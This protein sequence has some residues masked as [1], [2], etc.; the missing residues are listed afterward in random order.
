MIC[1]PCCASIRNASCQGCPYYT[2]AFQHPAA[3]ARPKPIIF[4]I[5]PEVESEVRH[6]VDLLNRGNIP[7]GKSVISRLV[8][9]HPNNYMVAYANGLCYA[10][11]NKLDEAIAAF[12][13]CV[14]INPYC[15][16][17]YFN[18]AVAY[19]QKLNLPKTVAAFRKAIEVGD[20][21][22]EFMKMAS[23]SLK[24]LERIIFDS[25]RL[26]IDVYLK[27]EELFNQGFASML[28]KNF[29]QAIELF[30][31]SLAICDKNPQNHGNI[32]IC[33]ARLG[34]K[35][36]ALQAFDLALEIDPNYE[37]AMV[38]RAIVET[39]A[40]GE[41]LPSDEV[42]VTE[43]YKEYTAQNKSYIQTLLNDPDS[44]TKHTA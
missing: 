42:R 9:S 23:S 19:Q 7:A 15:E 5:N 8:Y 16:E 40:E 28:E 13:A 35:A 21:H 17:A 4:E 14:D 1:P 3:Q 41:S 2:L 27:S 22:D 25:Y 20:P 11:E 39:L 44:I 31:A 43:Y 24:D 38:N 29:A 36:E 37:P 12:E 26:P 30:T 32:G 6:A 33:H 18:L 34:R 10:M